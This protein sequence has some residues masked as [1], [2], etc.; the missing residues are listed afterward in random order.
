MILQEKNQTVE[1]IGGGSSSNFSISVSRKAFEILSGLY[2]DK[3]LAIIRE[4]GCNA[5]DSHVSAGKAAVPIRVHLPNSFEP[6]LS[7]EDDGLGLSNEDII[8][9]YS[10]YFESTK[11]QT[12]DAVGCLGL[13]SKSPFCYT[14]NFTVVSR[15]N[16]EEN[17]YL[18]FFD[19]KGIPSLT[20]AHS[21]ATNQCN[22]VSIKIPVLRE[23]IA[24]FVDA[25][26]NAFRW[27]PVRPIITGAEVNYKSIEPAFDSGS[28]DWFYIKGESDAYAIMGGIA[29]KID[30]YQLSSESR[31]S[32]S[33]L[34][35]KF[36]IGEID[37]TPSREALRYCDM[38]KNAIEKKIEEIK[39]S[40]H[41]KAQEAID[42][43]ASL[44]EA[45]AIYS[46]LPSSVLN[47]RK[48]INWKNIFSFGGNML[49]S[50]R[51]QIKESYR[52]TQGWRG[53]DKSNKI[54]TFPLEVFSVSN[55][56]S[57]GFTFF[58]GK[59]PKNWKAH[60]Y[61]ADK[62][63]DS[64]INLSFDSLKMLEKSGV[65]ISIFTDIDSLIYNRP[66]NQ[67]SVSGRVVK[68]C[69]VLKVKDSGYSSGTSSCELSAAISNGAKYYI[70][71]HKDSSQSFSFKNGSPGRDAS[72][73]KFVFYNLNKSGLIKKP[74]DEI[75]IIHP[76]KEKIATDAGLV[77]LFSVVS[78]KI[79]ALSDNDLSLAFQVKNAMEKFSAFSRFIDF[80][81][82]I[83]K[84]ARLNDNDFASYIYQD[85]KNIKS[86][87]ELPNSENM[88]HLTSL[89][90]GN[91][92]EFL[93]EEEVKRVAAKSSETKNN[94]F[95]KLLKFDL[96]LIDSFFSRYNTFSDDKTKKESYLEYL[97][98]RKHSWEK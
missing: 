77:S 5:A 42:K 56:K 62:G 13:G 93:S 20:L 14:D 29:Y 95:S 65:D 25:A 23:D 91:S 40:F 2:S 72:S 22:G 98:A 58:K 9:I 74:F 39:A 63:F 44:N 52:L 88:H 35:L 48:T 86:L 78:E 1:K 80:M 21:K 75:V 64:V 30:T 83:S 15:Y 76:S 36:K 60:L 4:L 46:S 27:F 79:E 90:I 3:P 55:S 71:K 94:Y 26:A 10:S 49:Y 43:A 50:C 54:E 57:T 7:I 8:K 84:D 66:Q 61:R 6:F 34:V 38:T 41:S 68:K 16:G 47:S 37:F 12:N 96:L 73:V 51:L 32:I 92:R 81:N 87:T 45:C 85:I 11:T 82:S 70:F 97:E 18:A 28:P 53:K 19:E 31:C 89:L 33:G 67:T 17:T 24:S 69:P 59:T